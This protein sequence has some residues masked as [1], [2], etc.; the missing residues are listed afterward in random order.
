MKRFCSTFDPAFVREQDGRAVYDY[1]QTVETMRLCRCGA[2][3]R[4]HFYVDEMVRLMGD[5]APLFD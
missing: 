2:E 5:G 4:A 3:D 1:A